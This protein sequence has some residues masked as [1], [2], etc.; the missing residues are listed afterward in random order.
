MRIMPGTTDALAACAAGSLVN[1]LD[2]NDGAR[3]TPE[4]RFQ[5]EIEASINRKQQRARERVMP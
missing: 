3:F 2:R 4:R 5:G 1:S